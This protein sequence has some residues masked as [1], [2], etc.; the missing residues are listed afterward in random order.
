MIISYVLHYTSFVK[1]TIRNCKN[2][3][4]VEER[5]RRM[6]KINVF[7]SFALNFGMTKPKYLKYWNTEKFFPTREINVHSFLFFS[8]Q[9]S[10]FRFP[11]SLKLI[12]Y[13]LY[14]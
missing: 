13:F 5:K 11:I 7:T 1:H 14:T 9:V 8:I 10:H 4:I 3:M 2:K 12:I 6:S